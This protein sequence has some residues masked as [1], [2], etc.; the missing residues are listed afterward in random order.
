MHEAAQIARIG[1][2]HHRVGQQLTA[3]LA[4]LGPR[5]GAELHL[6]RPQQR[7]PLR[8][9]RAGLGHGQLQLGPVAAERQREALHAE[10]EAQH[11]RHLP[12]RRVL[13]RERRRQQG[14][15]V[16][17]AGLDEGL[18][19]RRQHRLGGPVVRQQPP[20]P[21]Q[22]LRGPVRR[23]LGGEDLQG[24][25][26]QLIGEAT[27][28]E[29]QRGVLDGREDDRRR[30]PR[31]VRIAAQ[32]LF[33]DLLDAHALVPELDERPLMGA[34]RQVPRL[35][36]RPLAELPLTHDRP[37][38]AVRQQTAQHPQ[39]V[40][41]RPQLR[42]G[43]QV[44]QSTLHSPLLELQ[45]QR[46]EPVV[47][48]AG[49]RRQRVVADPADPVAA[50]HDLDEPPHIAPP[51]HRILLDA[52]DRRVLE[53]V[54]GGLGPV[55]H[56][57]E[58]DRRLEHRDGVG[59]RRQIA[60][61]PCGAHD[62]HRPAQQ[63]GLV[64][65]VEDGRPPQEP[66]EP[67]LGRLLPW[68]SGDGPGRLL[69]RAGLLRAVLPRQPVGLHPGALEV[70]RPLCRG[71]RHRSGGQPELR[72]DR[73]VAG[74][75][76]PVLPGGGGPGGDGER[77][78]ARHP[79]LLH[80]AGRVEGAAHIQAVLRVR[81]AGRQMLADPGP[82]VPLTVLVHPDPVPVAGSQPPEQAADEEHHL[83]VGLVIA[84]AER[85]LDVLV[86]PLRP[87]PHLAVAQ[88]MLL[89]LGEAGPQVADLHAD[90]LAVQRGFGL[91][92]PVGGAGRRFR[93]ALAVAAVPL[94]DMVR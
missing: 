88:Q 10:Q 45:L 41:A 18:H 12:H 67:V 40:R 79:E 72:L 86:P 76:Q 31:P 2:H 62:V 89:Q 84:V 61:A 3:A 27:A 50:H 54:R 77:S 85:H 49:Q 4:Q 64:Q 7:R 60:T 8:V 69:R 87:V 5:Q 68:G 32:A 28:A 39:H 46:G 65:R 93:G 78:T 43:A 14:A 24:A 92:H 47:H 53:V 66:G 55:P 52:G 38:R 16:R 75:D 58:Q 42:A 74:R 57:G 90:R 94:E 20:H 26:A 15:V 19:P 11:R 63:L 80:P 73:R 83:T 71:D 33:E 6:R 56:P 35:L 23:A 25:G 59:G 81:P 36:D 17:V 51:R 91:R 48:I 82:H 44:Q 30:R 29:I 37:G 70:L 34:Q 22:H 9:R 21:A 1:G 13:V